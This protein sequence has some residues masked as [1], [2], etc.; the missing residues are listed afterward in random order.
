[1]R[2]PINLLTGLLLVFSATAFAQTPVSP[3]EYLPDDAVY[4]PA[5]PKPE[6]ILGH[7]V[8]EWH[9]THDKLVF[10]LQ[11]LAQHSDRITLD[12][13]GHTHENR[14][15]IQLYITTPQNHA[16]LEEIRG[17]HLN[18]SDQTPAVVWQGFSIHGNEPSGSNAALLLAYHLAAAKGI[19]SLLSSVVVI[20]DPCFNPDGLQRFSTWVNAHKSHI[21]TIDPS[22]REFS[23]AWPG[24]RTNHYWFD[25]NRDWLPVQHP[26]SQARIRVYQRWRPHILTDHHE[27]GTRSTFFFQPGIPSRTN[28]LTPAANQALTAEIGTYHAQALNQI[29]S[30]YYTK[31]SFDDFYYGKGSTYP[32]ANGGIGILFEQASSRGHAQA[33]PNG[34]LTFPFTI[35]NQL[36][37]AFSTLAAAVAM[38]PKLQAYQ[39]QFFADAQKEAAASP[40]K[41]FVVGHPHDPMRR[42]AFVQLLQQHGIQVHQL[43]QSITKGNQQFTPQNAV[44]IPLEQPAYRLIQG[45]FQR[46]DRFT[47]SLFYDI[48]AWT[49]PMAFGMDFAELSGKETAL[50]DL[51]PPI[52][53]PQGQLIETS[54]GETYA[55]LLDWASHEAPAA[56]YALLKA[57]LRLKVAKESFTL[58]GQTFLPGTILIPALQP[59]QSRAAAQARL[60]AVCEQYAVRVQTVS[61]GLSQAGIDLGSPQIVSLSMP[62]V[63]MPVGNGISPYEAGE[64][65]HLMDQRLGM[66]LTMTENLPGLA[67]ENYNTLVL[68]QGSYEWSAATVDRIRQWISAGGQ[69][70]LTKTAVRWA[71]QNKL[72]T[73]ISLK[74][75]VSIADS[76]GYR[77]YDAQ[78]RDRGAHVIGGVILEAELDLS[79]PLT[80]GYTHNRL[81]VFKNSTLAFQKP[82]DPYQTPLRYTAKPHLS[83]YISP[84]NLGRIAGTPSVYVEKLGRGR[85][86]AMLDNPN[87]RGFWYGTNR[88]F[89]NALFFGGTI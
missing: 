26:E 25:L 40:T 19:D 12:T 15:L 57:G 9:A 66:P 67:L 82:K 77:P 16:R 43:K 58:N 41:A 52:Q 3:S 44:L 61:T 62:R 75:E 21:L 1:M 55:Y 31:E 53:K 80:F 56:A 24:G 71:I 13:I 60:K 79:H 14:P 85:I 89:F 45:M 42:Y 10:Y 83:G 84:A 88:L 51:L 2:L 73:G 86:I 65:W 6:S 28:P 11:T 27:M 22:H 69:L 59:N 78:Q 46:L 36:R 63:L 39:K 38:R 30:L 54:T 68:V 70:I 48:S 33:S 5:I 17:A 50:G 4:D 20:L 7:P 81:P 35:R 29:G 23:E 47:D 32:D 18:F 64:V 76:L 74:K 87:F 34:V 8:G 72:L 37:T 49:L